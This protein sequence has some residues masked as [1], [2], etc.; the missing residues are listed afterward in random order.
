[1]KTINN[2]NVDIWGRSETNINWTPNTKAAIKFMSTKIFENCFFATSNSDDLSGRYQQG[3]TQTAL[4][5][6]LMGR[7]ISSSEDSKG[8]G[9]WSFVQI[10][11]KDHRKIM[12]VTGY[13]PCVQGQCGDNTVTAQQNDS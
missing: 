11:R 8:L 13:K 4:V 3:R 9:R 2:H 1:M 7:K 5:N 6:N 12:V 10:A